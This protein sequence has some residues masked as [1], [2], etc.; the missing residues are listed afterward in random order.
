MPPLSIGNT[1]PSPVRFP[2]QFPLLAQSYLEEQQE[3]SCAKTEGDQRDGEH[4]AGQPTNQDG[5][6]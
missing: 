4:L 2:R 5:A 6:D 1:L 3:H